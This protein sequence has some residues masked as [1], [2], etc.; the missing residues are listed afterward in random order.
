MEDSCCADS[1]LGQVM[2]YP[3]RLNVKVVLPRSQRASA[4]GALVVLAIR[5]VAGR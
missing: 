4:F 1:K 5:F 2:G 3:D